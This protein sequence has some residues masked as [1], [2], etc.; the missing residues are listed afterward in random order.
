MVD[1]GFGGSNQDSYTADTDVQSAIEKELRN[2]ISNYDSKI[3]ELKREHNDISSSNAWI[4][5]NIKSTF[6]STLDNYILSF[7]NLRDEMEKQVDNL[8]EH[9]NNIDNIEARYS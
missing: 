9:T 7:E 2:L 6:L 1:Q 5:T 4:D 8:S 3:I